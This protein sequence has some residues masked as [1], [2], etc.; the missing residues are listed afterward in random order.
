M[1]GRDRAAA[2]LT[3]G[4]GGRF[5][6]LRAPRALRAS[7]GMFTVLPVAAPLDVGGAVAARAVLWLPAVGAV[8][9][10]PAA[11]VL[12]LVQ[13]AVPD[14]SGRLLGAVLAVGAVAL[15]TGGLHLDGLADTADGLGSRRPAAEA[16]AIMRRSDVGPM[17]VAALVFVVLVQ[18]TA[19][20]AVPPGWAGAVALLLAAVTGR[21]A[22]VLALGA[23]RARGDG[24]GALVRE[25]PIAVPVRWAVAVTA[26]AV[27]AVGAAPTVWPA[28]LQPDVDPLG[29]GPV[30]A[31]LLVAAPMVAGLLAAAVVRRIVVRR[32]SG[33]TGDTYGALIE[34]GAAT[35]LVTA[36][37]LW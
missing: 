35:A 16:L 36:A 13:A 5:R 6:R 8:V 32:L 28:G 34:I 24:F 19:L 4:D 7:F 10:A 18:V 17:G 27:P 15:L 3:G 1:H 37:L 2:S 25:V 9:G 20:A 11:G 23:P 22:V 31:G 33:M 30:G 12:L 14:S 26:T 29:A 21:A